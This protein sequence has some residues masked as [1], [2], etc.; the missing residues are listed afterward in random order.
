MYSK[1]LLEELQDKLEFQLKQLEAEDWEI[2]HILHLH[3]QKLCNLVCMEQ[4]WDESAGEE[5]VQA[6]A[7]EEKWVTRI[8]FGIYANKLL[9]KAMKYYE[10][11]KYPKSKMLY[12]LVVKAKEVMA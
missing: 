11:K 7:N 12:L 2:N 10:E 3:G 5:F 1:K 6:Y 8:G 4:A 9:N